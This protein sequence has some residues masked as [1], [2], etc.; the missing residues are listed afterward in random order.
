MI[1]TMPGLD[2]AE[3][4]RILLERARAL[5]TPPKSES[6][7]DALSLVVVAVGPERYGIEITHIREVQPLHGLVGVPGAPTRWAGLV[8]L[9]GTMY[10]VLNLRVH[11]GLEPGPV[12]SDARVVVVS[13]ERNAIALL[14]DSVFEVSEVS[15]TELDTSMTRQGREGGGVIRGVTRDFLSVLDV[16]GLMADQSL[17]VRDET[18]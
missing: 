3:V 15:S 6:A 13:D 2:P 4:E 9:R 11:L 5:A 7:G 14:V 1:E 16:D 18:G 12:G 8:N 10:P 17:V